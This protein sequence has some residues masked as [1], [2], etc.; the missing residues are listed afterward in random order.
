MW[1][2][3]CP[4]ADLPRSTFL[5]GHGANIAPVR[6]ACHDLHQR[7]VLANPATP[8]LRFRSQE[9]VGVSRHRCLAAQALRRRRRNARH[10]ERDLHHTSAHDSSGC[11]NPGQC[12][13]RRSRSRLSAIWPETPT[14]TPVSTARRSPMGGSAPTP[15]CRVPRTAM[16]C[17][18]P[19]RASSPPTTGDLRR[20]RSDERVGWE[21]RPL[22]FFRTPFALRRVEAPRDGR[23]NDA[24]RQ[25][26]NRK[27][28]RAA[29]DAESAEESQMCRHDFGNW[30]A[31]S[32]LAPLGMPACIVPAGFRP[33]PET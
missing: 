10:P 2:I 27:R 3:R 24:G 16:S 1:S 9:L 17:S 30:A 12:P 15:P 13:G 6:C 21:L 33:G 22:E 28:R 19:R 31:T 5:N 14:K 11:R 18:P 25:V 4:R 7:R 23:P 20:R 29:R 8:P 26:S 32:N